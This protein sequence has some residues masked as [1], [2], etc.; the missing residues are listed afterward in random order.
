MISNDF[1]ASNGRF[2]IVLRPNQ[3]WTWRA[4][5]YLIASLLIVS[6]SIGI[7]FIL[8]DFW[9][10]L[11]F[12]LTEVTLVAACLYYCVRRTHRQ[13]VITLTQEAVILERGIR[14]PDEQ[15]RFHR[16]FT[17]FFV[18][19]PRYR[20]HRQTISLRCRDEETEIGSFLSEEEKQQLIQTLREVI[21]TLDQ[22]GSD[23]PHG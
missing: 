9:L 2:M 7:F 20:G 11:P 8:Q 21:A 5:V 18:K 1:D 15:Q 22:R 3:S 13:E 10:I 4:N 6:L 19:P 17:R 12:T 14:Q 16:Y 23:E